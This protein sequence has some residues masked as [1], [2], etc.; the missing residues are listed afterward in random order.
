MIHYGQATPTTHKQRGV[1]P[2][3]TVW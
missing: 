3:P 1:T 2:C